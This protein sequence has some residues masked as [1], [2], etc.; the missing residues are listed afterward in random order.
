MAAM[1][2]DVRQNLSDVKAEVRQ[3]MSDAKSDTKAA[4]DNTRD[5]AKAS[6]E[7]AKAATDAQISQ[8]RDRS[9]GIAVSEAQRRVDE[10]F[11]NRNIETMVENAASREV[12]PVIER[13]LRAEVDRAM[14]SLQSDNSFLGQLADAGSYLRGGG[15]P[16][17]DKLVESQKNAPSENMRLRAASLLE[18]IGND[19]KRSFTKESANGEVDPVQQCL[20]LYAEELKQFNEP[21]KRYILFR[22][23]L[24]RSD[25]TMTCLRLRSFSWP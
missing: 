7:N 15:R 16:G 17:L 9:A 23:W 19:Y 8:I 11:R 6:I 21:E 13:Q 5:N 20:S 3:N 12:A 18:A 22:F 14:L 1:R 4:V 25:G 10:A 2:A 24:G